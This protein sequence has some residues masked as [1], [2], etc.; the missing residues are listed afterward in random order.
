MKKLTLICNTVL[1]GFSLVGCGNQ[2][3]K[4]DTH[5]KI[6]SEKVSSRKYSSSSK[7]SSM[8]SS[9]S[10][11][12]SYSN[13]A[14]SSSSVTAKSQLVTTSSSVQQ[15][16]TNYQQDKINPSTTI[17]NNENI[18]ITEDEARAKLGGTNGYMKAEKT[19]NGW[20]FF[21]PSNPNDKYI[22][23]NNGQVKAPADAFKDI[24]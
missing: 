22:V 1:L 16:I 10:S 19:S 17:N 3:H 5:S 8:S 2:S 15:Q 18:G 7:F 4:S 20:A 14:T 9:S 21:D 12:I 13:I 11:S 24:Q 6:K 23:N